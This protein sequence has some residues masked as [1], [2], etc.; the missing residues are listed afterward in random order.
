MK[1]IILLIAFMVISVKTYASAE[2]DF[3]TKVNKITTLETK[4][5]QTQVSNTNSL[6]DLNSEKVISN[7]TLTIQRPGLMNMTEF[8]A[9]DAKNPK[10]IYVL[11]NKRFMQYS[12]KLK[13]V[14]ITTLAEVS[15]SLPINWLLLNQ[16]ITKYYSVELE[17]GKEGKE[18]YNLI[19]KTNTL[20]N[21]ITVFFKKDKIDKIE[22]FQ[23]DSRTLVFNLVA[24]KFNKPVNQNSFKL[25]IPEDADVLS[26]QG[27]RDEKKTKK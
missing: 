19:P 3:M 26:S 6:L 18:V 4:F 5:T 15:E 11:S 10:H 1:K 21:S 12:P 13:Q 27:I 24:P 7:G 25:Y 8:L 17:S 2:D 16:D 20:F 22:L 14:N 9:D 23:D